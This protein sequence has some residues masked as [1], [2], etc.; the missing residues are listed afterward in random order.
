MIW[1]FIENLLKPVDLGDAPINQSET[2]RRNRTR[3]YYVGVGMEIK[4]DREE[5]ER[6]NKEFLF[7]FLF[8]FFLTKTFL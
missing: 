5:I 3:E 1:K 4:K 8:F 7:S 2:F 6:N